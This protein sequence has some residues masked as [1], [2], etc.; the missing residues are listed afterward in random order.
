MHCGKDPYSTSTIVT[1]YFE[2][3][4][5]EQVNNCNTSYYKMG[6]FEILTDF[7]KDFKPEGDRK[8]DWVLDFN[9][10]LMSVY[11]LENNL[12]VFC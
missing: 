7:M 12:K 9:L 2:V 11:H 1:K 5:D 3:L 6:N 4:E 10:L 8:F